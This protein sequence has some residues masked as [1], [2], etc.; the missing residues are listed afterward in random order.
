MSTVIAYKLDIAEERTAM[1]CK[2]PSYQF[3]TKQ[4]QYYSGNKVN[5]ILNNSNNK[6][7]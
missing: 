3:N 2:A 5:N 1:M 7:Q 6:N 4:L